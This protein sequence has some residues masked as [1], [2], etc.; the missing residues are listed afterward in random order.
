MKRMNKLLAY[1]TEAD[2]LALFFT[3]QLREG[4]LLS[5]GVES[6]LKWKL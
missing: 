6:N 1:N 4:I 2:F 5:K 3:L